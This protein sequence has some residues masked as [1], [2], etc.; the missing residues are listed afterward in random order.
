MAVAGEP[1]GVGTIPLKGTL[2]SVASGLMLRQ[3][4]PPPPVVLSLLGVG[5]EG[6]ARNLGWSRYASVLSLPAVPGDGD[7]DLPGVNPV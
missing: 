5:V 3:A 1:S 7:P 4:S 2:K 6:G